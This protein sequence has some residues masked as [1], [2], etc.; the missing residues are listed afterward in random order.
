MLRDRPHVERRLVD[1]L[2]PGLGFAY[3][4]APFRPK[5]VLDELQRSF[6]PEFL[7]R[8][9]RVVVFRPFERAQMRALLDKELREVLP[10]RGLRGRPWAVELDESA[11]RF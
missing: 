4:T 1:R 7:N 6:R 2:R 10:C 9:D 5:K 8:I 3:D 11:D